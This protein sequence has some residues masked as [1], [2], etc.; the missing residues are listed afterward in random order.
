MAETAADYAK[1]AMECACLADLTNDH[2]I[3]LE[4]LSLRQ[5]FLTRAALLGLSIRD[6]L[7]PEKKEEARTRKRTYP[8]CWDL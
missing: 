2:A 7:A 5:G 1:R 3:Q 6:A 4:L 8:S